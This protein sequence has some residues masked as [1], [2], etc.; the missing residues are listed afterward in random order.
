M[1]TRTKARLTTASV[2]ACSPARL[3][4]AEIG[5]IRHLRRTFR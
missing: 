1:N 3:D 5:L 2:P 4:E